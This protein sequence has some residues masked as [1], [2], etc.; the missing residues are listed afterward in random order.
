MKQVL[1]LVLITLWD[2]LINW[3]SKTGL[4]VLLNVIAITLNCPTEN[5][6]QACL[7]RF[8]IQTLVLSLAQRLKTS[9]ANV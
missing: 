3:L 4:G 1:P 6:I 5:K 2:L 8:H 9:Y 7:P